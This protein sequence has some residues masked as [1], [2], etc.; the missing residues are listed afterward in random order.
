MIARADI[1]AATA[2]IVGAVGEPCAYSRG[3]DTV[4]L[5]AVIDREQDYAAAVGGQRALVHRLS[6]T[7]SAA[8]LPAGAGPG[9]TLTP[10]GTGV[11]H[12]VE[13]VEPDGLGGARLLLSGA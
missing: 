4:Q 1:D 10:A 12:R 6:A 2:T 11:A 13:F 3:P 8:A 9:D 5:A 7:V